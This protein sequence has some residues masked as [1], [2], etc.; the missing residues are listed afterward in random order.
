M[1]L[2]PLWGHRPQDASTV[3]LAPWH[4]GLRQGHTL[5][6]RERGVAPTEHGSS[7]RPPGPSPSGTGNPEAWR[8]GET[9]AV[10]PP[11]PLN[12]FHCRQGL[13]TAPGWRKGSF[14]FP[15]IE[16][17][18]ESGSW[19]EDAWSSKRDRGW[20]PA[21]PVHAQLQGVGSPPRWARR[22]RPA[23]WSGGEARKAAQRVLR[24]GSASVTGPVQQR[25]QVDQKGPTR[26]HNAT[27]SRHGAECP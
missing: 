6:P 24:V 4:L 21:R 5:G 15:A 20:Q 1:W 13:A 19:T 14:S 25:S 9:R 10:A 8:G 12:A 26:V 23:P 7:Y 27:A 3:L 22:G 2:A 18:A 16:E 11:P 17:Q